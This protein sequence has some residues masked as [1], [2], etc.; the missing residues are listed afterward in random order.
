MSLAFPIAAFVI[1]LI[2]YFLTA[3]RDIYWIDTTEFMLCGRFLYLSHPPG[4]PLLTLL[5]HVVS[6]VPLFDMPFR[7]NL[8][9]SIAAAG[10]CLFVFLIVRRLTRDHV[11][12]LFASL[13]WGFSFE[14]WSQATVLEAYTLNVLLISVAVYAALNWAENGRSGSLFLAAFAVGLGMANHLTSILWIPGLLILVMARR[15]QL[16]SD[17]RLV[18]ACLAF[19]AIGP[20]LYLC[21]PF[22]SQPDVLVSWGGVT[23]IRTLFDFVSGRDY[24][25][26]IGSG[27]PGYIGRQMAAL[28][29]LVGKQFL[30]AWVLVIP[31]VVW[32]MKQNRRF[33]LAALA[34][35]LLCA[36]F[37]FM[38]D[39]PDKEGFYLPAYLACVLIAG[40]G[41]SYLRQ[42][43]PGAKK[44]KRIGTKAAV[45][46]V[47]FALLL[48][49]VV[50]FYHQQD[51]HAL[52][53]L[54]DLTESLLAELPKGSVLFTDDYS[55]TRGMG[56]LA[57]E[58]GEDPVFVV[59]EY[60]LVFP[61]YIETVKAHAPV[62]DEAF[63]LAERLW[64]SKAK[65]AEF[66]ELARD[67]TQE[68]KHVLVQ[69]WKDK[70]QLF[71]M[72]RDFHTWAESWYEF[73][74]NLRG[75]T[76][77]YCAAGDSSRDTMVFTFPGPERYS[78][79][80]FTDIETQDLCRRFAATVNRRGILRF[81]AG[82]NAGAI[83]DFNLALA[84]LPGYPSAIEN[85]GIVFYYSDQPDSA[86]YYLNTYLQIGPDKEEIVKVK[87]FLNRLGQ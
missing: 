52:R 47:G 20:L 16:L 31:G 6:F 8:V 49:P 71:W 29:A 12:G 75:L 58:R 11:A 44:A 70:K 2:L 62:P 9:S 10:S 73:D 5:L 55:T 34:S 26:R 46:S 42:R 87:A 82:D 69:A 85:K 39:I 66:G 81:G 15:Q 57:A 24:Q 1:P 60:L 7:M 50:L 41:F 86:R 77:R 64:Q 48:L 45:T 51:R 30:A 84:Y 43:K 36:G 53:G 65:G 21:V 3:C 72:P 25:Y 4:Y 83:S 74:L 18:L 35:F 40:A 38:Y 79:D 67:R 13:A 78:T 76:Y 61:W 14:M 17:W 56:W 32:C 28:P 37:A 27:A 63:A 23:D 80:R 54:R 33:G 59:C 22:F 68:V 19:F